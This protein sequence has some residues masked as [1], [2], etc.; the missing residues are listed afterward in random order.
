MNLNKRFFSHS[1]QHSTHTHSFDYFLMIQL[2]LQEQQQQQRVS[3]RERRREERR[4]KNLNMS[5]VDGY[6]ISFYVRLFC[7]LGAIELFR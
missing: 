7:L 4:T 3:A 2:I 1:T 5:S 6:F